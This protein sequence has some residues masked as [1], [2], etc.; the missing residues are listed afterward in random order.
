MKASLNDR[1]VVVSARLGQNA[2][3][4]RIVELRHEDGSP[5]YVVAW[6]DTG[7]RALYFP[8]TDSH[9]EHLEERG[10]D[11]PPETTVSTPAHVKTW[12]VTI[13]V[14]EQGPN[15]SAHVVLHAEA[16]PPLQER[17]Y[18]HRAD[19]DTDVPEIGDELAVARAL[20]KLAER[21]EQSADE[22]IAAVTAVTD[23][24]DLFRR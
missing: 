19:G 18:A 6:S 20:R 17:G 10:A 24:L 2:R 21:L 1:I 12:G 8:G 11:A 3:E 13:H 5:P 23:P 15:T 14:Y 9:I 7:E 22:D 16:E 4:G